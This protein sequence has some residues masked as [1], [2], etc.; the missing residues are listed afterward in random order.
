MQWLALTSTILFV[1]FISQL[2]SLHYI[3]VQIC[4]LSTSID[5]LGKASVLLCA[6]T[7]AVEAAPKQVPI[8]TSKY[9]QTLVQ[10]PVTIRC[11]TGS[12]TQACPVKYKCTA[13]P[14]CE[15]YFMGVHY[16]GCIGTCVPDA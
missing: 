13:P 6:L 5:M 15:R 3:K 16:E 10:D 11:G 12:N 4:K 8:D 7:V 14:D 9:Q 1:L 2:H